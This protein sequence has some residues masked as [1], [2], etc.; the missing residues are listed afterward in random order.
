MFLGFPFS[1]KLTV[2][3]IAGLAL[4][5]GA[6]LAALTAAWASLRRARRPLPPETVPFLLLL[7][8]GLVVHLL[9]TAEPR[10]VVPLLPIP[11]WFIGVAFWHR[12]P[13]RASARAETPHG[14]RLRAALGPGRA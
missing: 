8:L 12:R 1:F 10:M 11:L 3:L 2:A 6:L 14:R 13:A 9:P 4:F 5:N 7:G